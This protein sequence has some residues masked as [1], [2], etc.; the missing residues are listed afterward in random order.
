MIFEF[1]ILGH[2]KENQTLT[3]GCL[4]KLDTGRNLNTTKCR[5]RDET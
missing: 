4:T 2:I 3:G 1:A 5:E